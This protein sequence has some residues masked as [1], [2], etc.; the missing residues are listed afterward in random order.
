[1]ISICAL[2]GL[3]NIGQLSLRASDDADAN[4]KKKANVRIK[5]GEPQNAAPQKP[6]DI[7][8]IQMQKQMEAFKTL[9]APY[10]K[11]NDDYT[12]K[13]GAFL[14]GNLL[15][16]FSKSPDDLKA[17]RAQVK[18]LADENQELLKVYDD[19]WV[20]VDRRIKTEDTTSGLSIEILKGVKT[21]WASDAQMSRF[22]EM[23]DKEAELYD[24]IDGI[25]KLLQ[26]NPSLWERHDDD[27]LIHFKDDALKQQIQ[28]LIAN[29]GMIIKQRGATSQQSMRVPSG[30]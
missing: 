7:R 25:L 12:Q 16:V 23:R 24:D 13:A 8:Q 22:R 15:S 6:N 26:D 27:S 2:I 4:A 18:E 9:F 17:G 10:Q 5:I 19:L 11:L 30:R 3:S 29:V 1:M 28:S 14:K 20:E 21:G